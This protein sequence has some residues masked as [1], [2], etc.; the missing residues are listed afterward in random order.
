MKTQKLFL[1]SL[2]V[3]LTLLTSCSVEYRDTYIDLDAEGSDLK[4]QIKKVS[5]MS[6]LQL[7]R[8]NA[9]ASIPQDPKNPITQAKIDLGKLLFH[10]TGL[11]L[12]PK[13]SE[14]ANTYSCASCH[15]RKDNDLALD[16]HHWNYRVDRN[17]K[18][19]TSR[20]SQVA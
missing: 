12:N 13:K 9:L 10:E 4:E 1:A 18:A 14:G 17:C 3:P 19:D 15:L 6:E 2:I 20:I 5:S 7:L 11:A 8:D 16:G